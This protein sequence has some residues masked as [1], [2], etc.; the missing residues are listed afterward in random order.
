MLT[1]L[2]SFYEN[3]TEPLRSYLLAIREFIIFHDSEINEKFKYKLPFF[4]YLNKPFCYLWKNKATNA[5]YIGFSRGHLSDH[6]LLETGNRTTI[7]I[8]KLDIQEDIDYNILDEIL[9][10]MKDFY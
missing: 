10:H 7:K 4:Y 2:D 6:P 3:L 5:P 9:N 8:L 1:P